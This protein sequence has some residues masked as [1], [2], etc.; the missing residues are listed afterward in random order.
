MENWDTS[1]VTDMSFMFTFSV[2]NQNLSGWCVTKILSEPYNFHFLS[3]LIEKNKPLWEN[4]LVN[5]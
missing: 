4:A 1:N 3:S 5:R 2:F